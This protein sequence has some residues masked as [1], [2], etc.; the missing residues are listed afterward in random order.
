MSRSHGG[1][2]RRVSVSAS[3]TPLSVTLGRKTA[4]GR[5][6]RVD[7]EPPRVT[8]DMDTASS[9]PFQLLETIA[10]RRIAIPGS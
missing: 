10:N 6:R 2:D 1:D 9:E 3:V 8:A 5:K 4:R 7:F